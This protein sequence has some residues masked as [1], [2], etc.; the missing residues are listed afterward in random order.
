M[1]FKNATEQQQQ[2]NNITFEQ[3]CLEQQENDLLYFIIINRYF[4][5]NYVTG[6][7]PR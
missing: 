2:A 5:L 4:Q 1:H 7:K 3:F 6:K